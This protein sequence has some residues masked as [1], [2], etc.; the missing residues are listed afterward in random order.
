VLW[1]I[2][3][4]CGDLYGITWPDEILLKFHIGVNGEGAP[5]VTAAHPLT[6][7]RRDGPRY[8]YDKGYRDYYSYI[9]ELRGNLAMAV[10]TIWSQNGKR[11]FRVYELLKAADDT[12]I[13]MWSEVHSLGDYALFLGPGCASKTMQVPAGRCGGLEKKH[14]YYSNHQWLTSEQDKE[15]PGKSYLT[16]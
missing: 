15:L 13:Y 8:E 16:R 10:R 5:V 1:G 12:H 3:I 14:I 4:Y 7:Q 11:F 2:A 6:V 9:F